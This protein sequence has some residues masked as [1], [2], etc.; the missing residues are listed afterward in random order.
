MIICERT[1]EMCSCTRII[2]N[3]S[4]WASWLVCRCRC[5]MVGRTWDRDERV[6]AFLEGHLRIAEWMGALQIVRA[7]L[8]IFSNLSALKFEFQWKK[9]HRNS[10]RWCSCGASVSG[11]PAGQADSLPTLTMRRDLRLGVDLGK[12]PSS[13]RRYP[14]GFRKETSISVMRPTCDNASWTSC[15]LSG[16][17]GWQ[18]SERIIRSAAFERSNMTDVHSIDW[19]V[20]TR[21]RFGVLKATSLQTCDTWLNAIQCR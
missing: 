21:Q 10:S 15:L 6:L 14:E 2:A 12:W 13:S 19:K 11:N 16:V 1:F 20:R 5:P 9:R 8:R 7:T 18:I 4:I 3:I 17:L